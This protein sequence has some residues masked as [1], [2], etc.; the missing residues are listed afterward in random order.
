MLQGSINNNSDRDTYA[1][2][3]NESFK[4]GDNTAIMDYRTHTRFHWQQGNQK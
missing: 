4:A 2:A 3:K 1:E